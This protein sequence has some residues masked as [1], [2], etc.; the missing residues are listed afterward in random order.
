[1]EDN[2]V[3]SKQLVKK[4]EAAKGKMSIADVKDRDI[5]TNLAKLLENQIFQI[6]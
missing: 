2:M 5:K 1:M 3:N 4:W 6:I